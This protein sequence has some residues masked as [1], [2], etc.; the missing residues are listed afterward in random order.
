MA[1][2]ARMRTKRDK[3]L[4]GRSSVQARY[5]FVKCLPRF[6]QNNP[7]FDFPCY[8]LDKLM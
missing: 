7:G 5:S 8:N 4:M 1:E 6:I 2:H 3:A